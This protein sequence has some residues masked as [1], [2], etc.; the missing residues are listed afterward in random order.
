MTPVLI[1]TMNNLELTKA[2]IESVRNQDVEAAIGVVDNGSTDGTLEW[3]SEQRDVQIVKFGENRGVSIGW[4]VGLELVFTGH[5]RPHDSVLVINNDAILPPWFLSEL[6][7][8]DAPFVTGVAVDQM[9]TERPQRMPLNPHPDFS[10]YLIRRDCWETVG[11]FDEHMKLYA[12]DCDFHIR[13]HR[14]GI[15]LW[16]AN[17][18]YYHV[19]SQTMKRAT[20]EARRAIEEQA[21][22]DREVFRSIYG[23]LPGE[24]AYYALFGEGPDHA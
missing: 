23:C 12:S 18:P 9:P 10:A 19:N 24:P 20:P 22:K 3:L 2:C 8:Y 16:K 21:N 11:P 6:L 13:A 1:L 7:S 4:N 17:V 15:P 5:N 14:L